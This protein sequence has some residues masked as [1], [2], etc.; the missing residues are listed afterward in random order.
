MAAGG[1]A[2]AV[3]RARRAPLSLPSFVWLLSHPAKEVE[4]RGKG[5]KG[6]D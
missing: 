6:K 3:S 5:E 2:A 4:E 1:V